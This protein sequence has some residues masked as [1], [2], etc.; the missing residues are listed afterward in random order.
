M[1]LAL[2]ARA[3]GAINQD[4]AAIAVVVVALWPVV[5]PVTFAVANSFPVAIWYIVHD[6][7]RVLEL[8]L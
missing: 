7:K 2:V 3:G 1:A 4:Q 5:D 8:I 6:Q